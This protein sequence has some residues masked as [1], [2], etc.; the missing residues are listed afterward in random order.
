MKISKK[1]LQEFVFLP[2]S[3]SSEELGKEL[4]MRTVEVEGIE[5]RGK[6]LDHIVVAKIVSIEKHPNA[7]KLRVCQVDAGT[8][9]VQ[10][11]CGG[12]NLEVGMKV[13][14]A[15]IGASVVWHGQGDPIVMEKATLRGV[16]S[17]GMICAAEEVGLSS[18]F[19]K[20]DDHEVVDLSSLKDKPGTP[21]A[22]ALHLDDVTL[23]VDNKSLSNRPDLWGH[24]GM[25]REI[26]TIYHK[27]LTLPSPP[28]IKQ[29]SDFKLTVSVEDADLC[30]RYMAVALSG[31]TIEPSPD[32]MQ[33]RLDACGIRPINNIVDITNYVMLELGQPCHAF[34]ANQ[35]ADHKIVVRR[36]KTDEKF[37]TLDEKEHTL[38]SDMLMI[39]DN[40][41]S[42]AIAG[43]MGGLHSGITEHTT[44]IIFESATFEP[45]S[46]R[47]T[48]TKLALRTDS[49]ARF[50]KSL[51]PVNA[52]LGLSRLVELTLQICKDAHVASTVIDQYPKPADKKV[53]ETSFAFLEQ[54]VGIALDHKKVTDI[55][56]RLGFVIAK[57]KKDTLKITV[58]SWRATKDVSLPE[59]LVEE[60]IRIIGYETVPATLPTFAITPPRQNPVKV[61][62]RNIREFLA[63]EAGFT[64]TYNYSFESPELLKKLGIETSLHLELENP[65]A[66]DRPLI[67]RSLIP[68][69]LENVESNL[70]RFD[71]IK[72]FETG[73][74]YKIEEAGERVESKDDGLLPRQ[75]TYLGI[76]YA[77]KS[78]A[79]P[80]F[81]LSQSLKNV[82]ARL[83]VA[84]EI[85]PAQNESFAATPFIHPGRFAFLR[86]GGAIVGRLSELHPSIAKNLGIGERVAFVE[87]NLNTLSE[88]CL[89]EVRY[90]PLS[91]Y[92]DVVR[93]IAIVV[94]KNVAHANVVDALRSVDALIFSVE[95]FD[96][97][98][99]ER[100]GEN[101]KSMAYHIIYRSTERTL[102][103]A[104]VDAVHKKVLET[105][106]KKFGAEIR[107]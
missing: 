86:V 60:I 73:R 96:V 51:D 40:Q 91:M 56:E 85:V 10:I 6:T 58:P 31:I 8:E 28:A 18:M 83:H 17:F 94:E 30:P 62:E 46:I 5:D 9:T 20:K 47:K 101:K 34:D 1:W 16:D 66:K 15:K 71:E 76:V 89:E 64:E 107:K 27:K 87:I 95:L 78:E 50:E 63:L 104:E 38:T 99:G 105:L 13:V 70:H 25:A 103:T 23:E 11:V 26:A 81:V 21:L 44:S 69:L 75:D 33:K 53:I 43:V 42:L 12:S 14:L 24:I 74:V 54:K 32:W 93:D 59:D 7:D 72:M 97:Y 19:P 100:L 79:T 84:Y 29:G 68:N 22:K 57:G 39:A 3:L 102:T 82:F 55:L 2:D 4:T 106:E 48:S 88:H 52:E 77:K 35:I 36:A 67:R 45:S 98:Q 61:L 41:K 92:P 65:I 37:V 80:F 49:S 90:C